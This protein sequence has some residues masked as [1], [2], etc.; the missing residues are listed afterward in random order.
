MSDER[1]FTQT[2][3]QAYLSE[4]QLMGSRCGSCNTLH[5]PPRPMCPDCYGESMTWEAVEGDGEIA[6][7]T[8]V[9]IGPSAMIAA[10]YGRDNPYASAVVKLA[11]GPSISGQVVG[12]DPADTDKLAV[13]TQVKIAFIEREGKTFLGFE[14]A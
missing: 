1:T 11:A 6:A 10:G 2:S 14:P 12:V 13:G 8:T 5:L 3:F 4:H 9:Y 7:Y